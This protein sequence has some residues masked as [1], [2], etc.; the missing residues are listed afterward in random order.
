M[1]VNPVDNRGKLNLPAFPAD[2]NARPPAV[3]VGAI[4]DVATGEVIG[5]LPLSVEDNGDG[6]CTLNVHVV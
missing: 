3:L 6:T 5:Y 2:H 4:V 1:A